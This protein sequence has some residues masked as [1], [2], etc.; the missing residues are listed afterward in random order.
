MQ[1]TPAAGADKYHP[2]LPPRIPL[3]AVQSL[4]PRLTTTINDIDAFK[5]L[6]ASGNQDGSMP[7]W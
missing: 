6:I 3:Q 2:P 4:I 7:N 1:P 5:A